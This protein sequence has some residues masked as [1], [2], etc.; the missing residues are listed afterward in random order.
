MAIRVA[1][2][3]AD[4][5]CDYADGFVVEITGA[6]DVELRYGPSSLELRVSNAV[7]AGAASGRTGH[8]IVGM[9]ERAQ[10]LGGS[11][12]TVMDGAVFRLRATLP[13]R[14]AS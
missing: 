8:G 11:L 12:E 1:A 14:E 9:R 4:L 3:T 6:S 13:Y 10:L 5:I 2:G 7:P